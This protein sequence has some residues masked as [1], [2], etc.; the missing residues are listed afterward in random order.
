M[1]PNVVM[2][3]ADINFCKELANK[4]NTKTPEVQTHKITE[5]KNDFSINFLGLIGERAVAKYLKLKL[6]TE[7]NQKGG[8]KGHDMTLG[9]LT[10][11]VKYT[12]SVPAILMIPN[13]NKLKA[14]IL[15]LTR[16]RYKAE[17]VRV[18]KIC[19]WITQERFKELCKP[20]DFGYGKTN[21]VTT[22]DLNDMR[23][24]K[25]YATMINN[26]GNNHEG[27]I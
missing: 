14:D 2:T 18:I 20:R 10:L 26:H 7:I 6:D 24:L 11:D 3:N 12:Q 15:I 16:P 8:D 13:L 4:R 19:G 9:G 22:K 27:G 5:N 17:K 23:D 1:M 25:D 21:V